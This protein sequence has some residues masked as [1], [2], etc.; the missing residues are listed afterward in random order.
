MAKLYFYYGPMGSAKTMQLLTSAYNFQEH[1]IP[2]LCLKPATDTR[3]GTAIIKSRTGL[4]RPCILI[5]D[6]DNIEIIIKDKPVKWILVDECQFLTTA[7]VNQLAEIVDKNDINVMCFGLRTD[8]QSNLFEGSA[9]L[10][11]I[12]DDIVEIK[13]SCDCGKKAIINA[14]FDSNGHI[15]NCGSQIEIGGNERYHSLCRACFNYSKKESWF[16]DF[17]LFIFFWYPIIIFALHP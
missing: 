1:N 15:I 11:A 8:F 12:A 3:D 6:S 7:Q 5:S 17:F 16:Q 14:R 10:F 9:R 4:N 13:S 2:I